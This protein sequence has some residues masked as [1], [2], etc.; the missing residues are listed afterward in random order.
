M[1][2]LIARI[3]VLSMLGL[4]LAA[5]GATQGERA[6][7]GGV[8]GAAAGAGVG[9]LAGDAGTGALIGGAAGTVTGAVTDSDDL[10]LG[11]FPRG[12]DCR[13]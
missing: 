1:S 13:R 5:C 7:S 9:A 6:L 8:L 3:T 11:R 4:G 12:T 10:C 2:K